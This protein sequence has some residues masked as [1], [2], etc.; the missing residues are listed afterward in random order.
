MLPRPPSMRMTKPHRN[1]DTRSRSRGRG[2]TWEHQDR[3]ESTSMNRGRSNSY[4]TSSS[5]VMQ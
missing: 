1:Q 2:Q 3:R 4:R 5:R